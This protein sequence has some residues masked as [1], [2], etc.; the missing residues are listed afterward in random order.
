[1]EV[2]NTELVTENMGPLGLNILDISWLLGLRPFLS[3]D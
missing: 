2:F 1:M 3:S